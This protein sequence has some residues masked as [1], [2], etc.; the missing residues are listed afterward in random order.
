MESIEGIDTFSEEVTLSFP[1]LIRCLLLNEG[2]SFFSEAA[3][4]AEKKTK[5][6]KNK[7][8]KTTVNKQSHK[9]VSLMKNSEKII[10]NIPSPPKPIYA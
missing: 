5:T 8:K 1:T 9:N 3:I 7:K 10:I 6:K 4:C 2:R